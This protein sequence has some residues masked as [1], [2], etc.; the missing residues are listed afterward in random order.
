[1][2]PSQKNPEQDNLPPWDPQ[3]LVWGRGKPLANPLKYK[4]SLDEG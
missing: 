2:S 1:M 3:P 4:Q